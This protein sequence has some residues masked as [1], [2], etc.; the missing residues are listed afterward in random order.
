M[1]SM[2]MRDAGTTERQRPR[3]N[4]AGRLACRAT[5]GSCLLLAPGLGM[6]APAVAQSGDATS[7][8]RVAGL[9]S[10]VQGVQAGETCAR[11]SYA[12]GSL[13]HRIYR[14]KGPFESWRAF[15]PRIPYPA[16]GFL[17]VG[18]A[19]LVGTG[20]YNERAYRLTSSKL[21]P[22]RILG[23]A[24]TFAQGADP[25]GP[26]YAGGQFGTVWVSSDLG[27]HWRRLTS[28]SRELVGTVSGLLVGPRGRLVASVTNPEEGNSPSGLDDGVYESL[29]AGK[30]WHRL[31][32]LGRGTQGL[33]GRLPGALLA[34]D[35]VG[36]SRREDA[37]QSWQKS[38]GITTG[39]VRSVSAASGRSRVYAGA[40]INGRQGGAFVSTDWGRT[41]KPFGLDGLSVFSVSTNPRGD[42][43]YAVRAR[44]FKHR[45]NQL[46]YRFTSKAAEQACRMG[47]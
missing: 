34:R 8:Q 2:T 43:V 29:D 30:T 39:M 3:R 21:T 46:W 27:R 1:V 16:A 45:T 33:G 31:G 23:G 15:G 28:L 25:R 35:S 18:D 13:G 26:V 38:A 44:P 36:V 24:Q 40:M 7:W 17:P 41:F 42:L 47:R 14:G 4:N 10:D 37:T 11:W 12:L 6:A 19:V 5:L 20:P 9:R 32:S 22:V